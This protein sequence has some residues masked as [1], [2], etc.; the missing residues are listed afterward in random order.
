MTSTRFEFGLT[1]M[2]AAFALS[3]Q[4]TKVIDVNDPRPLSVALDALEVVAGIPINYEDP[5]YENVADLQDVSTEQQ[6]AAKPGFRLLVP[7]S[8]RV[9]AQVQQPVSGKPSES[10]VIL[11]V[12]LLLGVYRQNGLPGEFKIEQANGMIYVTPTKVLAANGS[13]RD[14]VSPMTALVT[15]PY[16]RRNVAETAEAIFDALYKATGLRIVIGTFPFWSTD[17]V[18]FGAAQ[19]PARAALARLFAQT[20]RGPLSYRLTFDPRPDPMRIFDY[21]INVQ[22]T[23]YASPTAPPGLGPITVSPGPAVTSQPPTNSKGNPAFV[24]AKQ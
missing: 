20:G 10:D 9:T 15:V 14:V 11:N 4:T 18:S 16:A 5:P 8:G 23:G 12:D 24:E 17:V 3:A 7:R 13:I 22:Q 6:R 1:L 21:M 19:E 2:M